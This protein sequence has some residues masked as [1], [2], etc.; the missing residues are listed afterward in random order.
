[1]KNRFKYAL[2]MAGV[3]TLTVT[4]AWADE[5]AP[6]ASSQPAAV[7]TPAPPA[8]AKSAKAKKKKAA[9]EKY[10]WV[11]HMCNYTS[12]KPGKCP[13]CG[14]EMVKEKV[15]DQKPVTDKGM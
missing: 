13:Y 14:M 12:T 10:V 3:L 11:C 1:M 4:P 9:P 2:L 8:K 5:T 7:T 15:S 6:A